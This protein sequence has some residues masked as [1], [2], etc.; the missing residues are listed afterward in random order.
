[1]LSLINE[2]CDKITKQRSDFGK[3]VRSRTFQNFFYM[4]DVVM[5]CSRR[6]LWITCFP[7]LIYSCPLDTP[8][9]TCLSVI[10]FYGMST[11][12]GLVIPK[13]E[14]LWFPIIYNIKIYLHNLNR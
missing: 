3:W 12:I 13:T 2:Y 6:S 14:E 5:V 10:W 7:Q 8:G 1:M 4:A 9:I 11:F